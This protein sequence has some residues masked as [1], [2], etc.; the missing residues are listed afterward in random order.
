MQSEEKYE[1]ELPSEVRKLMEERMNASGDSESLMDGMKREG[2]FAALVEA[3]K[4]SEG[5]DFEFEENALRALVRAAV[6]GGLTEG[7]KAEVKMIWERLGSLGQ[8]ERGLGAE[9]GQEI[10]SALA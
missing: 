9:D 10:T 1:G 3:M 7:E 8:H 6:Q 5:G 4:T 2:V